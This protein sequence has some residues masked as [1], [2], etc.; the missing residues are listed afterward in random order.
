MSSSCGGQ[1][2]ATKLK[3]AYA[4]RATKYSAAATGVCVSVA[5]VQENI[6]TVLHQAEL[7]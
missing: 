7:G 6:I 1:M 4:Y 5:E 2:H 3:P